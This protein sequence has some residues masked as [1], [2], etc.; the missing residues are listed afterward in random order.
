MKKIMV[1]ETNAGTLVLSLNEDNTKA[2]AYSDYD[3]MQ[4]TGKDPV[5]LTNEELEQFD[6][7]GCIDY[8]EGYDALEGDTLQYYLNLPTVNMG[9]KKM[10]INRG[11]SQGQLAD[12]I[13]VAQ[14]HVS[15]WETGNHR[16]SVDVLIK[17]AEVLNC[18]ISDLI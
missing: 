6:Y 13:G 1:K 11:L 4:I 14:Q 12:L 18:N 15:R 8:G 16:P 7:Q 3:V 10:R 2:I 9:I 17:I 5:E